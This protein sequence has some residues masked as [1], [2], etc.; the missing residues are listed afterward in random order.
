MAGIEPKPC[1]ICGGSATYVIRERFIKEV[2]HLNP[3]GLLA[4]RENNNKT[5]S[6]KW[7]CRTHLKRK[8]PH[9]EL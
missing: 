6:A 5:I 4:I 7:Y 3:Y 1:V 8:Y 2:L 9:L